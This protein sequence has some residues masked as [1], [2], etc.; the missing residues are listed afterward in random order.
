MNIKIKASADKVWNKIKTLSEVED[1]SGG[2]VLK[3]RALGEGR[4]AY[5]YTTLA[6]QSKREEQAVVFSEQGKKVVLR[7]IKHNLPIKRYFNHFTVKPQGTNKCKLH[8]YCIIP[9][10][11]GNNRKKAIKM[12]KQEFNLLKQGLQSY[13]NK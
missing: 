6:D 10:D 9:K 3:S 8:I 11:K 5:R 7:S 2:F 12:L 1:Y 4:D 13:F